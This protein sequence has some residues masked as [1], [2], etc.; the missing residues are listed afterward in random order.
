MLLDMR[1]PCVW[2]YLSASMSI[3]LDIYPAACVLSRATCSTP[4]PPTP[5]HLPDLQVRK[6]ARD[7]PLGILGA[8]GI[9]TVCYMLMSAALVLMVPIGQLDQTAPFAAAFR[10][11]CVVFIWF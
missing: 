3:H 8:L 9:V 6:P 2:A 10:W 5:M 7:L 1:L 11:G 4:P